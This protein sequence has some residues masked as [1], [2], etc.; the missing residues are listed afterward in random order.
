M[1][2]TSHTNAL[3]QTVT[4]TYDGNGNRL[5]GSGVLG[6]STFTYNQ[7][8]EVLT[9]TDAMAGV[10]SNTFDGAGNPLS[11]TDALHNTTNFTYDQRGELVK[12]TN[13]RGKITTLAYDTNGNISQTTDALGNI[14]KLTYD[15]RGRLITATD[16]LGFKT[17]YA[18]DAAGRLNKI[19]RADNSI[20]SFTYDLA[21]RRTRVTDPLKSSTTFAYDPAYRLTS[22]TDA[23]GKSVTYSYDLVSNLITATDQLG[24]A[25]DIT[26]DEFNRPVT[27]TYPPALTGGPRLQERTEYDAS[28]NV[29]K[30]TGTAGRETIFAYDNAN[31][32]VNV[33][34][35]LQRVTQY[36]YNARSNVTAVVDALNQRYE[37][38][39]DAVGR[40][41]AARRAGMQMSFAYD[42]AGN[43][44]QR[45][46]HNNAT[47]NYQY[48]ALNR[49]TKITYPDS[50][51]ATYAYDQLSQLISAANISGSVSFVY[52]KMRQMTSTTDVWGQ[53]ISYVYDAGGRRTQMNLGAAKFASYTYDAINRLTKITDNANKS[54]TYTY[55][56]ASNLLTRALSNNVVTSYT[57]DGMDR[58]TRS[59]DAKSKAVIADNN[60][61]YNDA[62]QIIQNIDQSS[63][64][65][66]VYDVL[67]RLTSASYPATGNESY[68][69]DAVGNRTSSQRSSSYV[70][71]PFNRL[72][73][74]DTAGY[75]YDNNGNLISR[76]D[77][78]G[79]TS[80]AWDFE[81]RLTQVSTPA[82]GGVTYKYDALGRR[83]QRA[84]SNGASTN[85]SY[86]GAD[87]VHEKNSDATTV[88][89][90]N[91]PGVD[92]KIWQKGAA[93]YFFS[94]D[95]L[96]ST[97]A[98]T[99][100]SGALVERE[101]YDA[102]GNTAG[103]AL[104]RY[105]YTGRERDP[106]TGLQYNRAR[107]YDAQVGRFIS[108][109]PIGLSGGMN[110]FSY[111]GNNP[112]NRVDPSGLY[113]I[114]VHYYLTLYLAK[115]TGCFK[116]WEAM[117]I[118]NEDQATDENSNTKPGYGGTDQQR[119]QNRIFHDFTPS[120]AEG[121]G[122]PLLWQGAMNEQSDSHQWIGRYLH[123][124]Q[125]SFSHAG[126]TDDVV[127]HSP[128][129]FSPLS[130]T[131]YGD[132]STDKTASDPT[133]ARRMAY[134]TWDALVKYA[135][136]KHCNCSPKWD[137]A[138]WKDI[139][140]F[141]NMATNHPRG[142]TIDAITSSSDNPGV[143]D[144]TALTQK[145]RILGLRDRYS[146]GW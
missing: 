134:A 53:S 132:H 8:G 54:T 139:D 59:N 25:T 131:G 36:E 40:T 91:G 69:Y 130:W 74:T 37:F 9:A 80:F 45:T 64:H 15:A 72:T 58:L 110:Q 141:I 97:T 61:T 48:D 5:T 26:Y 127:G 133:R 29:T 117:D 121:V 67:D 12:M 7:F 90:L 122:S 138:L 65:A 51:T 42:A 2:L 101:S 30:R 135:S 89:Y 17:T 46:D 116:D 123:H 41:T 43:Q 93:Q 144:P 115:K 86:D 105:G 63:A 18:Y 60:Y 94:Q 52:D 22:E 129:N 111:V 71:Q 114:D 3:N 118:A 66:Y 28:G 136:A 143:G 23:L 57:Y 140:D 137:E 27:I 128:L 88:D 68:A 120:A 87:I 78:A 84:P 11:I 49:L 82:A 102:Y 119:M 85:F 13:A 31:R 98:L 112:Q 83:V 125:D 146:G 38:D 32:L 124:L 4:Y 33:T 20:V 19:T 77:A 108:E 62:N 107:W 99:N 95:H 24:H 75:L 1:N 6:T 47:T 73:N 50:T 142:S 103:S 44:T 109:D 113:E 14:T 106:L 56:A 92:N 76:S 10:T 16:A 34:D 55:D 100:T 104:T 21:G 35:P 145:R 126:F 79:A 96:G 39:Y 70:Y 81:N